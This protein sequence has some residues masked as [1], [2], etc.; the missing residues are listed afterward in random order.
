MKTIQTLALFT[1]LSTATMARLYANDDGTSSKPIAM[2]VKAGQLYVVISADRKTI[3]AYSTL[4]CKS[5]LLKLDTPLPLEAKPIA[6]NSVAA[7]ANGN[8]VYA[9]GA[10]K[11]KWARLD[12]PSHGSHPVFDDEDA[13]RMSNETVFFLFGH[14]SDD[15]DGIDLETGKTVSPRKGG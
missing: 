14:D 12:F 15:W 10:T 5:S 7:I 4:T 9:I 3:Y 8:I 6:A 13:I 1:L 2:W 11:G